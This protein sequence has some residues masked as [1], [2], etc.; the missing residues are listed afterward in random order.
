M[1]S[2]LRPGTETVSLRHHGYRVGPSYVSVISAFS[3]QN[4]VFAGLSALLS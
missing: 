3:S 2:N 1:M 4:M